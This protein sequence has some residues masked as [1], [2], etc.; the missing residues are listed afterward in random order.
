MRFM[1]TLKLQDLLKVLKRIT[2]DEYLLLY[3]EINLFFSRATF[4][5]E[6]RSS[7]SGLPRKVSIILFNYAY[8]YSNETFMYELKDVMYIIGFKI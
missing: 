4:A 7:S 5:S 1:C 6:Y 2:L 8:F 3:F